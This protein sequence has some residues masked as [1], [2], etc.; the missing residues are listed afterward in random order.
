MLE[1]QEQEASS[2]SS[3]EAHMFD[4]PLFWITFVTIVLFLGYSSRKKIKIK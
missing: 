2:Q 3:G 4:F 1:A